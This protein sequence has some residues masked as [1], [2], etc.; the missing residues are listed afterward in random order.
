MGDTTFLNDRSQISAP[1][2][3]TE[4]SASKIYVYDHIYEYMFKNPDLFSNM[5]R[6]V[7]SPN[8]KLAFIKELV[9]NKEL[10][11]KNDYYP[12]RNNDD[13]NDVYSTYGKDCTIYPN[14]TIGF[15]A[16]AVERDE[17]G[18]L[19]RFPHIGR[20]IIG[21][22]VTIGTQCNI[23]RGSLD[24]TIIGDNVT[25]DDHVH[26]AHNVHIGY[27]TLITAG[28]TI[29][30]SVTIG[31]DCWIGLGATISDHLTIGDHVLVA[32]GATVIRNVK[33]KDIVAYTPAISIK[34][35]CNLSNEK[36]YR[37]VGY[38]REKGP[39]I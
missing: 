8:P 31:H 29:G 7:S 37:M 35:K 9:N 2:K 28:A 22:N 26:I 15:P 17:D 24:D 21:N 38:R 4:S 18:N 20:V 3:L 11:R 25:I 23:S 13:T 6:F 5:D 33:D 14:T 39:I 36:L 16:L 12:P 27:N 10:M 19:V 34:D 32:A 30:G 1:R